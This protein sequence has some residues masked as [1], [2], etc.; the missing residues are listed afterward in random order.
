MSKTATK[1]R[2]K[3]TGKA[4]ASKAPASKAPA[5][6]APASKAPAGKTTVPLSAAEELFGETVSA[7]RAR[8]ARLTPREVE[9][10]GMMAQGKPNREIAEK[11][12][13][14]PKTLDIHRANLTHKLEAR[15]SAEVANLVN[16]I[17]L[18]DGAR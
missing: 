10:A 11:L 15:T 8:F 7:A 5:S 9:V 13:I 2:P 6:K 16:L 12:G 4:P 1:A 17:R 18:A 3:A 14:S